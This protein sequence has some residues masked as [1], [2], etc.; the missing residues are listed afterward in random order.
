MPEAR[1]PNDYRAYVLDKDDHILQRHDFFAE[2]AAA[3]LDFARQYV[4]GHDVEVWLRAQ[5]IGR[6]KHKPW[7]RLVRR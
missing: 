7:A 3:A 6:L 5:V 1:A 4:D 2:N